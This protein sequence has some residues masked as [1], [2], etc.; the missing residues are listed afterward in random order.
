MTEI[1]RIKTG[2]WAALRDLRLRALEREPQAFCATRAEEAR[3]TRSIWEE[4][5]RMGAESERTATFVVAEG[6]HLLGMTVVKREEERAEIYAVYLAEEA[7]GRGLASGML[8]LALAFAA[9][10]P[11]WLEANAALLPA[12]RLYARCGFRLDGT[13][14]KF[15]DGRV[16]RGWVR[17]VPRV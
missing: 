3:L 1:R 2:E 17:H 14:R 6:K 15:P 13:V 4:R 10:L 8:E 11:V 5:C 9:G 12:E 16:M 7:R